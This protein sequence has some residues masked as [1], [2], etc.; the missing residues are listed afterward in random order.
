MSGIFSGGFVS[1][2]LLE[3]KTGSNVVGHK[4][5]LNLSTVH[6]ELV[7]EAL[8]LVNSL[9]FL[10][11]ISSWGTASS[12][13]SGSSESRSS[14]VSSDSSGSSDNS[15]VSSDSSSSVS[16]GDSSVSSD[17][18]L[19]VSSSTSE[20]VSSSQSHLSTLGS[21]SVDLSDG[22]DVAVSSSHNEVDVDDVEDLAKSGSTNTLAAGSSEGDGSLSHDS[23]L[24]EAAS[25]S[26]ELLLDLSDLS[27]S[28]LGLLLS[29][30]SQ[31]LLLESGRL[32]FKVS[33]LD[34]VSVEDDGLLGTVSSDSSERLD[35]SS[36]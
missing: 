24:G 16:S 3:V 32:A 8:E 1:L 22:S 20:G 15:S 25:G 11:A 18:S 31:E 13:H 23:N 26:S 29:S 12:D 14:V 2:A 34:V 10:R 36:S 7:N 35:A 33:G 27:L 4:L 28:L 17:G 5:L 30:E 9:L 6:G 21:H 19:S